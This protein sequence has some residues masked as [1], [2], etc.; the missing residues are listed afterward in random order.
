MLTAA[1]TRG[2]ANYTPVVKGNAEALCTALT[3]QHHSSLRSSI[4]TE[5]QCAFHTGV[6]T[7]N[8]TPLP[9]D[10]PSQR[11]AS[12]RNPNL[13]PN[14]TS[15]VKAHAKAESKPDPKGDRTPDHI[16][17]QLPLATTHATA[18]GMAHIKLDG[19]PYES[20]IV[21][22]PA[23]GPRTSAPWGNPE[24]K[25]LGRKQPDRHRDRPAMR[26]GVTNPH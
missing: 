10:Y 4:R 19:T 25:G 12:M 18:C 20:P 17:N 2:Y 7:D 1:V 8:E 13:I 6:H 26:N 21:I 24:P 23:P 9:K 11:G 15:L 16:V 14:Q 22:D 5:P 3:T